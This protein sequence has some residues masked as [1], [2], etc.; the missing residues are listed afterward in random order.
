LT[1]QIIGTYA[2]TELG[3]GSFL[4]GIETTAT[5]D[6]NTQEFILNTPTTT[7]MKWWP[8][9]LGK[10]CTHC[11]LMAK[12]IIDGKNYGMHP[13]IVQIRSLE[14]HKPMPGVTLG[15]IG[16]KFAWNAIDNGFLKLDN[17]RIPRENMLMR[18]AKVSPEGVYTKPPH[19]K[20][21]Y[22][23]MIAVRAFLVR[24]A[25]FDLS[26][27]VTIAVR[28]SC[29]RRQGYLMGTKGITILLTVLVMMY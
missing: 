3:H 16:P 5:Y 12:L 19:A 23:T 10:T 15:D 27:G 4:R 26:K 22:G 2:Q 13:F 9:G 20:I 18:Y 8:G 28:Y 1:Y 6:K 25:A 21:A 24:S 14:D 17:V 29:V 11:V 7:S